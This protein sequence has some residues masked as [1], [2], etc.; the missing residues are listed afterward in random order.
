MYYFTFFIFKNNFFWNAPQGVNITDAVD[1]SSSNWRRWSLADSCLLHTPV[2]A[3]SC[4]STPQTLSLK[5]V[6]KKEKQA[7]ETIFDGFPFFLPFK[8]KAEWMSLWG[9]DFTPMSRHNRLIF[10]WCLKWLLKELHFPRIKSVKLQKTSS[11]YRCVSHDIIH[12]LN[13][14]L[15]QAEGRR[16]HIHHKRFCFPRFVLTRVTLNSTVTPPPWDN[17]L[18]QP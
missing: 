10:E 14:M 17:I 13:V 15:Q 12:H 1:R 16:K 2:S 9:P 4:Q 6:W 18:R 8:V 11:K 7:M 3:C 5:K